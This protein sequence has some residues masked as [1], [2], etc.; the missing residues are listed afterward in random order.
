LTSRSVVTRARRA[1]S[2]RAAKGAKACQPLR[3]RQQEHPR[4]EPLVAGLDQP[5]QCRPA[6]CGN[7]DDP[8]AGGDGF[9]RQ[10]EAGGHPI[11]HHAGIDGAGGDEFRRQIGAV[12]P[13]CQPRLRDHRRLEPEDSGGIVHRGGTRRCRWNRQAG[14]VAGACSGTIAQQARRHIR[15]ARHGRVIR[16][17]VAHR[18][19]LMKTGAR[20]GEGQAA[21][22]DRE[23]ALP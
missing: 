4:L 13:A 16:D 18:S 11:R 1:N 12:A 22:D 14:Q 23:R 10:S 15:S 5:R 6:A 3:A 21:H 7:A 9:D 17:I 20:R 19:H 2:G 8:I